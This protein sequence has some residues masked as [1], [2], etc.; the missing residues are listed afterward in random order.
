MESAGYLFMDTGKSSYCALAVDAAGKPIH[1]IGVPNAELTLSSWWTR[2]RSIR[3][4]VV[5]DQPGGAAGL[6]LRLCWQSVTQALL[7]RTHRMLESF[8]AEILAAHE[9][10]VLPFWRAVRSRKAHAR[11]IRSDRGAAPQV[12]A[13]GDAV[14]IAEVLAPGDGLAQKTGARLFGE[15]CRGTT[16]LD[17]SAPRRRRD[18]AGGDGRGPGFRVTDDVRSGRARSSLLAQR[19]RSNQI[20]PQVKVRAIG[21]AIAAPC[22]PAATAASVA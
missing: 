3:R 14:L 19:D 22:T 12:L 2:L 5:V 13:S 7:A 8:G 4:P 9:P 18:R 6:W 21:A 16:R 20:R 15:R 11:F 1:Q 10:R 17:G